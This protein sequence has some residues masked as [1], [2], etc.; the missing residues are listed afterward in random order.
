MGKRPAY[1]PVFYK[2]MGDAMWQFE[3]KKLRMGSKRGPLVTNRKQAIAIGLGEAG[4]AEKKSRI[5]KARR[6][7]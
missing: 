4:A 3:H 1:S 2:K 7:Q 5:R 6:G